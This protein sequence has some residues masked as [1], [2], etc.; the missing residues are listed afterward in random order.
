MLP[1]LSGCL[2]HTHKVEK[3]T[4]AGPAMDASVA[5]LVNEVNDRYSA[6][7]TLTA[8]VDFRT[9]RLLAV[10][11]SEA[12]TL[13]LNQQVVGRSDAQGGVPAYNPVHASDFVA[14]IY[15]AL[16]FGPDTR[17]TDPVGRPHYVVQ[18]KPVLELF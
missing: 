7:N 6:V 8:T 1:W 18:G 10:E 12:V 2:Y 3:T 5:Q 9:R 17:V 11:G 4:L 14:T 16:G 15:H 13:S